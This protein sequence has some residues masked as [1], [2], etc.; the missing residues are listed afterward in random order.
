MA[1]EDHTY[2]SCSLCYH[3]GFHFSVFCTYSQIPDIQSYT[4]GNGACALYG[5]ARIYV[6]DGCQ[7]WQWHCS[8]NDYYRDN[9][10]DLY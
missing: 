4:A 6:V 10:Y 7:E 5:Y 9:L 3:A 1:C 8:N 2:F